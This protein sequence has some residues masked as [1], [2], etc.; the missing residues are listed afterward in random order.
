MRNRQLGMTEEDRVRARQ[1]PLAQATL[2]IED[3]DALTPEAIA[4]RARMNGQNGHPSPATSQVNLIASP[5]TWIEGEALRQLEHTAALP[6]MRAAVGLPDLHPGKGY[7]IGAAFL[8]DRIY[9][10]L[11]GND[12][13]CGM[14]LWQTDLA[15]R[16]FKPARASERL[17]DLEGPWSGDL[18]HWRA[19]QG[20]VP[21]DFDASLGTIGGGNHFAELQTLAEVLDPDAVAALNLDSDHLLLLVHSGSRGLGEAELRAVIDAHGHQGLAPDSPAARDY[22]QA[23][24]QAIHWAE[25][26]RRLIAR[27]LL[28]ALN[29][30]GERR[31]DVWHNLVEPTDWA[32]ETLRL[33][34]K[35]AAP[36][37][38][39]PV[40]IPGSRGTLSYLV[41]PLIQSGHE[42]STTTDTSLRSLAH[43][44]GRKWKRGDARPRLSAR[45]RPEDLRT[46][47]LD[48]QVICDDKELLYD[49]AP[50]AY[51]GIE[52][53]VADLVAA[54]LCQIIATLRPVLT[55]KVRR[56]DRAGAIKGPSKARGAGKSK[57]NSE[58]KSK[59][60]FKQ[61]RR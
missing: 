61:A 60:K 19:E 9:P 47:A 57:P 28:D 3:T 22:L 14:G 30:D 8:A 2:P 59:R 44:A 39:G 12:I 4:R 20:L 26:N 56:A 50:E 23:H 21:T 42:T 34:R 53:V 55:Y 16:K 52:Q 58:P 27:R 46:T 32:G 48:S 11:V 6:G 5:D 36:A 33:H 10:A 24:D 7:P 40:V 1:R 49:E 43:G 18:A 35:G 51:K 31:L 29:A 54:G 25:A 45:Q 17:T 15:M 37:D 13:G 41:K 38:R